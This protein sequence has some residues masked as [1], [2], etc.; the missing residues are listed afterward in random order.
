MLKK[1]TS[2]NASAANTD[3]TTSAPSTEV[4]KNESSTSTNTTSTTTEVV[5]T[6]D[7]KDSN[8]S[9][10]TSTSNTNT[11]ND[12]ADNSSASVNAYSPTLSLDAKRALLRASTTGEAVL[13]D[14]QLE[15]LVDDVGTDFL[16][17]AEQAK[18]D[19]RLEQIAM[20]NYDEDVKRRG[21]VT[22]I[23][24]VSRSQAQ[25]I[26]RAMGYSVDHENP[27]IVM[28]PSGSVFAGEGSLSHATGVLTLEE[29]AD[30]VANLDEEECARCILLKKEVIGKNDGG[31]CCADCFTNGTFDFKST[32]YHMNDEHHSCG[33]DFPES[34]AEILRQAG[35][36]EEVDRLRAEWRHV[37]AVWH[38]NHPKESD[39][40]MCPAGDH[41]LC[42]PEYGFGCTV[43]EEQ[44]RLCIENHNMDFHD[45]CPEDFPVYGMRTPEGEAFT[46]EQVDLVCALWRHS[47]NRHELCRP[48][49]EM[50]FA[51]FE[52]TTEM[53]IADEKRWQEELAEREKLTFDSSEMQI[54]SAEDMSG[55]GL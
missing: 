27:D 5:L 52:C 54:A 49:V 35:H 4:S 53:C 15:A 25:D 12:S 45:T 43:E 1:N 22:S 51:E 21:S 23:S 34:E 44:A 32:I 41:D 33:L 9:S 39:K 11:K 24:R 20:N 2:A 17:P 37:H 19:A 8:M 13:T 30:D 48:Y 47:H 3:S 46:P 6:V 14:K 26:A 10:T 16:P 42:L 36:G 18:L 29:G 50:G 38:H 28:T 7:S 31:A 55:L 40:D